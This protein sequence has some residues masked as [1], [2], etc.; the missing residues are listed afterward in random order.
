MPLNIAEQTLRGTL[1]KLGITQQL[2]SWRGQSL[3]QIRA[4]KRS[5]GHLP[6]QE[7][8]EIPYRLYTMR[9]DGLPTWFG[10]YDKAPFSSDDNKILAAAMTCRKDWSKKALRMPVKLG[11]FEWSEVVAGEARF[12]QFADTST[13]SWQQ[14][15]MLQ[16]F[17]RSPDRLVLYNT[18]VNG[19]Y[20]SVLQDAHSTE[21]VMSYPVPVYATGP[22]WTMGG[23]PEFL[24]SRT[25]ASRLW[26][27]QPTG[28]DNG[29]PSPA[30]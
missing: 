5:M 4:W 8:Q 27:Q 7:Q 15:S 12:R 30:K 18:L 21:I 1:R 16:W 14:G 25:L 22:P 20:G 10:Y 28:R 3:R 24:A 26:V 2:R 11:F 19:R 17:P 23:E 13:W 6:A 9:A 29:G